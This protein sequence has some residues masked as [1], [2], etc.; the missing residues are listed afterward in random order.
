MGQ[1]LDHLLVDYLPLVVFIGLSLVSG[2]GLAK[3]STIGFCGF[4]ICFA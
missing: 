1:S 3:V 2:L 4:F